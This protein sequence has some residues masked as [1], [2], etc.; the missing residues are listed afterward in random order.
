MSAPSAW[1]YLDVDGSPR[2]IG[3]LYATACRGRETV[4][5]Q[6]D[7]HWID[8]ADRFAI[9]PALTVSRAPHYAG[10]DRRIF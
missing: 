4:T 7:E 8:M 1:V 5:S 3:R 2:L 9:E 6:Y 10:D